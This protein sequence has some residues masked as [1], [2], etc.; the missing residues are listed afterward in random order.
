MNKGSTNHTGNN[1]TTEPWDE[2]EK[3]SENSMREGEGMVMVMECNG[4]NKMDL[5]KEGYNKTD[6]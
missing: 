3:R 6:G 5:M 1:K 4:K 2:H